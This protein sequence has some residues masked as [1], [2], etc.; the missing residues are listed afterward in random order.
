[1]KIIF[2]VIFFILQIIPLSAEADLYNCKNASGETV[3]QDK[4]CGENEQTKGH[5]K[6]RDRE[7]V[8]KQYDRNMK[9]MR[10]SN[11]FSRRIVNSDVSR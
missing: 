9:A 3:F 8:R 7:E 4:P 11:E 1:M 2:L 6:S 10:E 5:V